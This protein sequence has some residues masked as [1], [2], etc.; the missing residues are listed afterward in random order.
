[1]V[2]P[3]IVEN[4]HQGSKARFALGVIAASAVWVVLILVVMQYWRTSSPVAST[5]ARATTQAPATRP[6]PFVHEAA[7]TEANVAALV[8]ERLAS[9]HVP[10]KT[11][12]LPSDLALQAAVA[13]K[14]GDFAAADR[15]AGAVLAHS[16]LSG[17]SF[18]P[19]ASFMSTIVGAGDDSKL[20]WQLHKWSEQDPSSTFAYLISAQYFYTTGWAV[21]SDDVPSE[22]PFKDMSLFSEDMVAAASDVQQAI[23]LN[24]HVPWSY[25]LLLRILTGYGNTGQME[26]AFQQ[27]IH[28]YPTYYP[29]YRQ[30]L[31]TLTPKWGGSVA[32]MYAF[33]D[34]Y[35]GPAAAGSPLKL[36]YLQLY[37][38]LADASAYDC[39]DQN[40][41]EGCARTE[42]SCMVSRQLGP[43]VLEALQIYKV[44]DPNA[45]SDAIWPILGGMLSLS[46]SNDW[47]G[48]SALLQMAGH[49]MGSDEQIMD[50]LP[51]HN[52]YV[53][54]DIDAR[55]FE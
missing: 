28:A 14:A 21:R 51:G 19:F 49:V 50:R 48:L 22:I 3:T 6:N 29:L 4:R 16:K 37:A 36:L 20:E 35:A 39:S 30:R 24:P 43:D 33:V 42:M 2:E 10:A 26:T 34:R 53:L 12:T 7:G 40:D 25:Y 5:P 8:A 41:F 23:V 27:A 17:W 13:I 15:V 31:Y 52:N 46:G 32:S 1:M 38:Y 47:S 54:D 44:S 9:L 18:Y 55:I 45:Y 11:V